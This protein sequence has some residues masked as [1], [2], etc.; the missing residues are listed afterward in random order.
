MLHIAAPGIKP[1]LLFR[2]QLPA[3]A[4]PGRQH[5]MSEVSGSLPVA[6]ETQPEFKPAG[7]HLAWP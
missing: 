5:V 1:W 7:I 4:S 6:K 3:N 2:S